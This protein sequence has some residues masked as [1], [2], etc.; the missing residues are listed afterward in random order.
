MTNDLLKSLS[1][2][3]A[4]QSSYT[5][6]TAVTKSATTDSSSATSSSSS[7]STSST[8]SAEMGQ[9]E[10]L[11]LL[12]E[13]LEQQDPLNPMD[14][15][16]FAVQLAQF[17]QLEQ[18][19]GVNDTLDT[20]SANSAS[21]L[22][23]LLGQEVVFADQTASISNGAGPNVIL[24]VPEGA[25]SGRID[26]TNSEGTVVGS[27]TLD[28]LE[29]GKQ[30]VDLADVDVDD[31]DYTVSAVVVNSEG[32]FESVDAQVSGTVEGFVVANSTLVVNGEEISM[33]D[34]SEVAAI[35]GKNS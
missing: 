35:D 19:I 23:A 5:N 31:G 26:F 21:S 3:T 22:A 11:M 15:Q 4:A 9:Q 32:S 30:V 33:D 7:S 28:D 10:F 6:K 18:L 34:I 8:N 20:M 24:D 25:T 27:Y 14:S 2:T 16:E 17:S 12:C 1:N 13:Q 29:S